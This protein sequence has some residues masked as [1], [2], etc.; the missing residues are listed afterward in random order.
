MIST[1]RQA[2]IR[3]MLGER[4]F[5]SI[6]ELMDAFGI[7]RSS[8]MRDLDELERQ[9]HCLRTRGG[10]CLQDAV[11]LS[12]ATEVPVRQKEEVHVQEKALIC[13]K[14]AQWME[15][16]QCIF[17]D[18]GTTPEGLI[19]F[20]KDKAVTIVTPST[21]FLSR[22]PASFPGRIYLLGGEYNKD[23]DMAYGPLAANMVK[24]FSFDLC[25]LTANGIDLKCGEA[26]VF[27]FGV[28]Q[29]KEAVMSRAGQKILLADCAKFKS[30]GV[31]AFAPLDAFDAVII[32][33]AD[34]NELPDNFVSCKEEEHENH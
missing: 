17:V 23:Y 12:P 13:A 25:F 11:L 28:G 8:A 5:V 31:C 34:G 4:Q 18:G 16:G 29:V 27:D 1:Q 19:P 15:D 22:M 20:L 33:E 24:S 7:S 10:A 32:D 26:T 2:K 9:G 21:Y 30:R 6:Q 14:A 3:Q